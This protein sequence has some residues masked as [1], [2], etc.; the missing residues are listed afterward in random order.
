[1]KAMILAAGF[2]TRLLPLT[3]SLPKPCFP[4][5]N[6]PIIVHIIES[7][8]A[9]GV[10]EIVI[11]L[12]HLGDEIKKCVTAAKINGVK[13]HYS[14]EKEILGTAG[15][16]K[17]AEDIL[18]DTFILHNGDIFTDIDFNDAV[19]FHRKKNSH[20][21][22]IVK[23][24]AHPSF[25]GLSDDGRIARF[26]YGALKDST[27]FARKTYFTGI[28]ILEPVVFDYIP[29]DTFYGI[30]ASVY[31]DIIA[32]GYNA[33]GYV[34]DATWL[35]IGTPRD[36][37]DIN[38]KMLDK[39]GQA[40]SSNIAGPSLIGKGVTIEDGAIIGTYAII[41]DGCVIRS[42]A[43][44]TRSVILSGTVIEGS[45]IIN[46]AIVS[47]DCIVICEENGDKSC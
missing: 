22:M 34:T 5:L 1:M 6:K 13:I 37:L 27:N 8:Q 15:G 44:V 38:F 33:L 29:P 19:S 28:H 35:D 9:V 47:G 43:T 11:N 7:L 39:M 20:A 23:D 12:H 4:V 41:G 45:S 40:K 16:I 10:T 30:N 31:P 18:T 46:N 2:G 3:K 14:F 25:I 17:K 26:P 36:F 32:D 42:G 24:G 21:T